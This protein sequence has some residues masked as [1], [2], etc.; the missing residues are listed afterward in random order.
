LLEMPLIIKKDIVN[1]L[2]LPKTGTYNTG[3]TTK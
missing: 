2:I 3:V 1:T